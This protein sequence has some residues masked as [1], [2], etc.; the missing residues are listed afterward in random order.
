[1]NDL[2]IALVVVI[3]L[4]MYVYLMAR[5]ITSAVTRSYFETKREF[6]KKEAV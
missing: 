4:P 6:N 1:M 2:L 3:G 5:I